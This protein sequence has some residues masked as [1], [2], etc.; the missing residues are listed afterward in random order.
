M[1]ISNK[2]MKFICILCITTLGVFL[3]FKFIIPLFGPF[4]VAYFFAWILSPLVRFLFEKIKMPKLTAAILSLTFVG[5]AIV[6]G[7]GYIG[8]ILINQILVLLRNLPIYLNMLIGKVDS[9]CKG[10]DKLLGIQIGTMRGVL[11]DNMD[12][13]LIVVKTRIIPTLTTRSLYLAIGIVEMVGIIL[14]VIVT[15]LLILKDNEKYKVSFKKL[16]LYDEIHIVTGR[17]SET[18]IAYLK[19]QAIL[20]ALIAVICS[21]GLLLTKNKYALLIGIGIGI[22]DAFPILGSGLILIPW[23][24]IS[25]FNQD[26]YTAAIL[27]TLYLL[28][29][30]I[31]Q[32]LEPKL[33][34]NRIGIQPVYTLMSMYVGFSLFG[35]IGFFLGPIG[36]III[37]TIMNEAKHRIFNS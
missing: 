14:V 33:L 6:W 3:G 17:L 26:I 36:L 11:D 27:F 9:F 8:N 29:Q 21:C 34:G 15:I 18:G 4:L 35:F 7:I 2:K 1:L 23:G 24:I 5:G 22:F 31:R 16:T 10:C 13:V 25:L 12:S 19:T 20:M 28:C 30:L 32:F 37:I